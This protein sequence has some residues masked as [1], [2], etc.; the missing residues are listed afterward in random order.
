MGAPR[1]SPPVRGAKFLG[2]EY[3][4]LKTELLEA[5][6]ETRRLERFALAAT[7]AVWSWLAV[8][9]DA[10]GNGW[11]APVILIAFFYFRVIALGVHV[12]AIG[13]YLVS[14]ST[15]GL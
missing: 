8:H 6:K 9:P 13:A 10:D 2:R 14:S 12:D 1:V 11:W 15:I 4:T 3:D 7:A 5:V